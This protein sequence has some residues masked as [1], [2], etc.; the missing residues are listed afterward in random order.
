MILWRG[1]IRGVPTTIRTCPKTEGGI[2]HRYRSSGKPRYSIRIEDGLAP[3]R[4]REII[5][6]EVLH[7]LFW[8]FDEEAIVDAERAIC[9]V[10]AALTP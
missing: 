2:V 9:S 5:I 6:H 10:L 7:A 3:E 1:K 4:K 8:D